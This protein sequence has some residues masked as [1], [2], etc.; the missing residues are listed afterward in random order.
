MNQNKKS[1]KQF[2]DSEFA[3]VH[4]K[5]ILGFGAIL[6]IGLTYFY[7]VYITL[8]PDQQ[9][10]FSALTATYFLPPAGKETIIPIGLARGLPASLWGLSIWI[11]DLLAC[12]LILTNWW[13]IEL[14]IN[15]IPAFTFI[16]IRKEKP[17]FYKKKVS[18]Q[19]W[20]EKLHQKT[21]Q[22]EAKKYGKIL[23]VA[24]WVFMFVPFQGTGAMSTTI[25][26]TWLGLK[27]REIFLIVAIGSL[28]STAFMISAYYGLL[29]IW[30]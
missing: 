12:V 22:I 14:L 17:R 4:V 24:L 6:L 1:I 18:L 16:G 10:W 21:Q 5:Q 2:I 28:I 9:N 15:H 25:I 13:V 23:P 29:G 8:T 19:I 7:F 3:I 26:G 11:Y 27:Y 30:G 20:Y